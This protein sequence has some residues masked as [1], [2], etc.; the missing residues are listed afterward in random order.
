MK[1]F[2]LLVFLFSS[3]HFS[4]TSNLLKIGLKEIGKYRAIDDEGI[5]L[6]KI[7]YIS[8]SYIKL[9]SFNARTFCKSYGKNFDLVAFER[10]EEFLKIRTK[11]NSMMEN[12]SIASIGGFKHMLDNRNEYYWISSGHKIEYNFNRIQGY[13]CLA[14]Q[15]EGD[16]AFV[17]VKCDS[18]Y[19]FICQEIEFK[20]AN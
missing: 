7:Y 8:Q 2:L 3:V 5:E 9:N 12:N 11:L 15:K 18:Q 14:V 17:N 6:E 4:K 13:N 20:Y 16:V 19:N 1:I 10:R